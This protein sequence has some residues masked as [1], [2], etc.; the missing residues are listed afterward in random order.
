MVG[1]DH[2]AADQQIIKPMIRA[3][4]AKYAAEKKIIKR[5]CAKEAG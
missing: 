3:S 4:A 5:D 2:Y 1:S